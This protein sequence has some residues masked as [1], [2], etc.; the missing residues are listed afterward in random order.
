MATR[1]RTRESEERE[2]VEVHAFSQK[3][4]PRLIL[5]LLHDPPSFLSSVYVD[6]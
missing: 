5:A 3:I 6:V 1:K 2:V 4:L